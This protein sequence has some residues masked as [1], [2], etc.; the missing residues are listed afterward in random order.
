MIEKN[1]IYVN[2]CLS[3]LREIESN[4]VDLII[5]DYPFSYFYRNISGELKK[6]TKEKDCEIFISSTIRE[7]YRV[8]KEYGN[9][10]IFWQSIM[11]Y[12]YTKF[13]SDLF[14]IRNIVVVK[15]LIRWSWAFLPFNYNLLYLLSKNKKRTK[16]W[17]KIKNL[18]DLW[19]DFNSRDKVYHR[20]QI[21]ISVARRILE[22]MSKEGDL[23][24]DVFTGG[25]NVVITCKEMNRN[26][27]GVDIDEKSV[28]IA[29][30]RLK[31]VNRC[32][33]V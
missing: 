12:K 29:N 20:E 32:L 33:F 21:P 7:F 26:F 1:K 6:V 9:L 2:D 10:A 15:G 22:L 28:K 25:G 27:I 14:Y 23:V 31:E 4:S 13:L 5:A 17:Y 30:N 16:C 19:L 8:L 18:T 3:L 24:L 11:A